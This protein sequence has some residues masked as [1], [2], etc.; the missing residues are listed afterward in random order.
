VATK[1]GLEASP[2]DDVYSDGPH[3]APSETVRLDRESVR[4]LEDAFSLGDRALHDFQPD[5]ER[6]LW[7]EHFDVAT[8]VDEVNFGVSP[9]DGHC[10][11]PYA[12]VGPHHAVTGGFWNAPFGASRRVA[13][14]GGAA[15]I[16]AFFREGA[17]LAASARP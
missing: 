9:G 6:I 13:D 4:V 7:P 14:L 17:A 1:A 12:Y 16:T 15:A 11:R 8:T 2:L 10:D 5:A 3:V